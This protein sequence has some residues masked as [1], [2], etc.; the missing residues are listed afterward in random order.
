MREKLISTSIETFF[1]NYYSTV[2][3][4]TGAGAGARAKIRDKGGAWAKKLKNI[5]YATLPWTLYSINKKICANRIPFKQ[6]C[7][8]NGNLRQN[9]GLGTTVGLESSYTSSTNIEAARCLIISNKRSPTQW[10]RTKGVEVSM[11]L[12]TYFT[13]CTV[14]FQE[15]GGPLSSLG[16]SS[17]LQWEIPD[18]NAGLPLNTMLYPQ[19]KGVKRGG[20]QRLS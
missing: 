1:L 3:S 12:H 5:C 9:I 14:F 8:N 7:K 10:G 11:R 16:G 15:E 17:Y 4:G 19:T 18:L 2:L 6:T 13:Y 20:A